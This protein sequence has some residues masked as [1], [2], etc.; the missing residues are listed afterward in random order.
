MERIIPLDEVRRVLSQNYLHASNAGLESLPTGIGVRLTALA[1]PS[2]P[3]PAAPPPGQPQFVSPRRKWVAPPEARGK[4]GRRVAPGVETCSLIP[5]PSEASNFG[6]QIAAT[7]ASVSNGSGV[8][9]RAVYHF[10]YH[11]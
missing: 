9:G 6:R 3:S 1:Q 10:V 7:C 5:V 8:P 4:V 11:D 2:M